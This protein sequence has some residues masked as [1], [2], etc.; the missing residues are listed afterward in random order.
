MERLGRKL[1]GLTDVGKER[2]LQFGAGGFLRAFVD[3]MLDIMNK[4]GS[5]DGSVVCVESFDKNICQFLNEQDGLYTLYLRGVREGKQVLETRLI[6]SVS[7]CLSPEDDYDEYMKLMSNSGLRFI[8][9]N[10]TEAGIVYRA[11]DKLTDKPPASFPAKVTALLYE[12]FKIFGADAQKGFIFIPCELIDN[13]GDKLKEIVLQYANDWL[14]PVDFI[15][16][17]NSANYFTNTLVDRI[18][19]GYPHKEAEKLTQELGYQDKLMNTGEHFHFFAIEL[20]KNADASLADELPLHKTGLNVIYS[21]DISPYKLRKVR[22]LN[23]AHTMSVLAAFLSGYDTVLDMMQ[24]EVFEKY[25]QQGIFDE[26]IPTLNLEKDE[27]VSFANAVS[28]RF[29]NPYIEHFLI[30]IALNSV[31]KYKTRVL[32]SILEYYNIK[33]KAPKLLTYSM[34]ALIAFYRGHSANRGQYE[35][36]DDAFVLEFFAQKYKQLNEGGADVQ[37]LVDCCLA[38]EQFWGQDLTKLEGFSKLVAQN[39]QQI[40]AEGAKQCLNKI[41]Q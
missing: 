33:G 39:L 4:E 20:P 36:K 23:G 7:R 41:L 8:V 21:H 6:T 25:L 37:T 40:F 2:V 26:I 12:R 18:V 31:S 27:L 17:V 38:N 3:W 28:D 15:D 10:T 19:T 22:I 32:P 1:M 30:S 29:K 5:F 14:L 9:S 16:W 35:I 11:E 13:N 24:D 34:A